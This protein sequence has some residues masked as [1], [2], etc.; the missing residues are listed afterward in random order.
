[1]HLLLM[2]GAMID[3]SH[4][5]GGKFGVEGQQDEAALG[6]DHK[7]ELSKHESQQ[8]YGYNKKIDILANLY[9]LETYH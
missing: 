1:M 7:E 9:S 8:G 3:A 4:G 2:C 6:F 5:F